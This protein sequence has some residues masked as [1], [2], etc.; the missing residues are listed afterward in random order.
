VS[1]FFRVLW[2]RLG[3]YS[4]GGRWVVVVPSGSCSTNCRN[5]ATGPMFAE[6][7]LKDVFNLF[8]WLSRGLLQS[9]GSWPRPAVARDRYVAGVSVLDARYV[10]GQVF[11]VL[12]CFTCTALCGVD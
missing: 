6:T 12:L 11:T 5:G 10:F 4:T 8:A 1:S 7:P 9:G 3:N 2:L